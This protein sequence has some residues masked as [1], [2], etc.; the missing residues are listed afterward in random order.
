MMLAV[1]KDSSGSVSL[2]EFVDLIK[3]DK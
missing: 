3:F 1:D 2:E